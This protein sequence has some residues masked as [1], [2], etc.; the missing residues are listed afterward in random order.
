MPK[1]HAGTE[2]RAKVKLRVIEFELE[3]GSAAVENSIRQITSSLATR[4][5]SAK[6]TIPARRPR[7]LA[8]GD[9]ADN[10]HE[11]GEEAA[12]PVELDAEAPEPDGDP[13]PLR[14]L[15]P[16]YKPPLPKY[17]PDLD[18][19]GTGV[20]FKEFA[21]EKAPRKHTTRYLVAAMWLKEHGNSPTVDVD[22][23]YTCYKTAGWPL[24]ITDWDS[25]FRSQVRRDRFR[26][27]EGG[28]YSITPLGE[29][30][31]QKPDGTA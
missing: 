27:A 10:H 16:K 7:E 21:A 25:N 9:S 4:S 11:V 22:K 12:D 5:T 3:G 24:S 31:L 20:P 28:G 26:R 13:A 29:A 14:P 30:D 18:T 19:K 6:P 17:L 2:E 23:V 15:K 1:A 8:S